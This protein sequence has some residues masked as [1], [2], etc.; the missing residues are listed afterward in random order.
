MKYENINEE[1]VVVFNEVF[2]EMDR[3]L[4]YGVEE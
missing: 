2:E 3:I 1:I 4:F